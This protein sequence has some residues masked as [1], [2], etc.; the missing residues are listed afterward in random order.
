MDV[1]SGGVGMG[2]TIISPLEVE[3][4]GEDKEGI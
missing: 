3:D 1:G 2:V 4:S